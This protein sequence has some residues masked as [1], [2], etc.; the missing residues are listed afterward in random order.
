MDKKYLCYCGLYCENCAVMANIN[1]A[2]KNLY[3][4]MTNAGFDKIIHYIPG[5]DDFWPF[6]KNMANNGICT[7]CK[8]GGG[9]PDCKIR[10]CAKE[11][12]VDTCALCETYPCGPLREF[13]AAYPTLESD[14]ALLREKGFD[15]WGKL[16]DE[17]RQSGFTYSEDRKN[18]NGK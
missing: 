15:E 3:D 1:P 16:Q 4:E 2:A 18:R 13:L 8:S 6:L 10:L 5:G 11:K 7:D 17:R 9:N 14:N 12:G